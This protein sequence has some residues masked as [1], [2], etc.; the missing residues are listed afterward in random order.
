MQL[1][2]TVTVPSDGHPELMNDGRD[3]DVDRV[4]GMV[5]LLKRRW[6]AAVL[7]DLSMSEY[8]VAIA[9]LQTSLSSMPLPKLVLTS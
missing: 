4:L 8:G 9:N 2:V 7:A 1:D 3:H 6:S 5:V